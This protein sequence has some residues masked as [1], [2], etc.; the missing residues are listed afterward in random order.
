V[1]LWVRGVPLTFEQDAALR[2]ADPV[3]NGSGTGST[4]N[5]ARR[6]AERLAA[7][8][9][10]RARA[11]EGDLLHQA[12]CMLYWAEGAKSTNAVAFSNSDPHMI[13]FFVGFLREACGVDEAAIVLTVNCHLG[14][15]LTVQDIQKWWLEQAGLPE[16]CLR[17]ATVDRVSRASQTRGRF[18]PFGTA[19]ISVHST[20]L[21][22]EIYG[23]IQA[24]AEF[25]R[26]DWLL[27]PRTK[28][29]VRRPAP[30]EWSGRWRR[31]PLR[32]SVG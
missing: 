19:R 8:D 4:A 15:G 26:P 17:K 16:R 1:S 32:G 20:R 10:G 23:A 5:S 14:A 31:L 28:D 24:Y 25:E 7:Q 21:V 13:R 9:A 12:G 11:R 29:C 22:Q 2:A 18:V 27:T 30:G 3:R 6:L